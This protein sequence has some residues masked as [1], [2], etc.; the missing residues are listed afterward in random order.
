MNDDLL[1]R[2]FLQAAAGRGPRGFPTANAP[3]GISPAAQGAGA[4]QP[5][6]DGVPP[7][8][9]AAGAEISDCSGETAAAAV[10]RILPELLERFPEQWAA[11]ALAVEQARRAGTRVIAVA[12]HQ[13]GEGKTTLVRGLGLL[14]SERGWQVTSFPSAAAWWQELVGAGPPWQPHQI[15]TAAADNDLVLVDAGIWFPPGPLRPRQL[16]LKMFGF[17]GVLLMRHHAHAPCPARDGAIAKAGLQSI[18]EIV[19]FAPAVNQRAA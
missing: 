19:S 11:V 9:A 12:G 15:G 2:A 10:D 7:V 14:L 17:D 1:D 13:Q 8:T 5:A 18:G 3:G 4:D 16:L 6:A